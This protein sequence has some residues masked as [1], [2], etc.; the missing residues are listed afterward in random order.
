MVSGEGARQDFSTELVMTWWLRTLFEMHDVL[1][2]MRAENIWAWLWS[3]PRE[4]KTAG[5]KCCGCYC[6]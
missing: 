2:S 3:R 4:L 1:S 6:E 5:R